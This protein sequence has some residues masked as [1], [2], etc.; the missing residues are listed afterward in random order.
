MYRK[1]YLE[2][3]ESILKNNVQEIIN[4]Y[5][6]YDYY[7]GVVKANAYG[8]GEHIVNALIE[9]GINYLAVSSL[10][11]AISI[12]N[13]NK[14][15]PILCFGYVDYSDIPVSIENNI[16]ISI[17]SYEYLTKLIKM[18]NLDG[19]KVHIK[20]NSGMN[21]FGLSTKEEVKKAFD[22]LKETSIYLEGIYTHYATS[23]VTDIYFDKQTESFEQLTSL[24]NLKE[25]PIV[26][27]Y[28]SL[29]LVKHDKLEYTNGVRLG[30]VMYGYSASAN[31]PKGIKKLVFNLKKL[32]NTHGKSITNT[33]INNS[34]VLNKAFNLYS[35]V[36]NLNTIHKG[37]IVGYQAK[38]V[39]KKDEKIA[40]IPIGH[41]DGI[42]KFYKHVK[43][44][45]KKYLIISLS[46][47]S[48][49]VLVDDSVKEH[50]RVTIIGDGINLSDIARNSG[51][52]IHQAL[53]SISS[54]VSRVHVNNNSKKEIR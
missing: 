48:I 34:L 35:E 44:N 13:Y 47:D 30:I 39:A 12:R 16:T 2:I 54:R 50:D 23:G 49:M 45:G 31:N 38:Y 53:V 21:R 51:I 19:L 3:N 1:T 5:S 43:I 46:M 14:S 25:I 27:L 8:H 9:G 18:D 24:I 11:E 37:D 28:N 29:A 10:D 33:H 41:A 17:L 36:V 15:I 42:T 40:V 20:V 6:K 26:H 32:I 52:S 7:F 4:H 22:I